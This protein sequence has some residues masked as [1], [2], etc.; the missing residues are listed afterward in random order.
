MTSMPM[1]PLGTVLLPGAVL[2]LHIFEDRYRQLIRT[3]LSGDV[4]FGITL[5]SQGSEVGGGESRTAVGV[6]ARIVEAVE[7]DDGRWAAAVLGTDRFRVLRW[8]PD[9]PFPM[10]EIEYWPDEEGPMPSEARL[11]ALTA[12]SAEVTRMAIALGEPVWP[13]TDVLP[14]DPSGASHALVGSSPL[15]TADRH[16]LL[17][18]AGPVQRFELFEQRLLDQRVLF[19]ARLAMGSG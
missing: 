5:I 1:F 14:T 10:A 2:P 19:G 15:G 18:A 17:C 7:F 11:D 3:C 9:D 6:I 8:T 4:R 13:S 12:L 16:D